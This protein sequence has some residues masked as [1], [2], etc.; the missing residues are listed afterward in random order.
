MA[1]VG[2]YDM[3]NV[4][5]VVVNMALLVAVVAAVAMAVY[6]AHHRTFCYD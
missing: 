1:V 2:D 6:I 5:L 3:L 4:V